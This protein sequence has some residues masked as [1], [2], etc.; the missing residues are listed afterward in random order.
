MVRMGLLR[1]LSRPRSPAGDAEP[2]GH[3]EPAQPGGTLG[4]AGSGVLGRG[5][6]DLQGAAEVVELIGQQPVQ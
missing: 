1:Y 5:G 6:A 3:P 2:D 4:Q